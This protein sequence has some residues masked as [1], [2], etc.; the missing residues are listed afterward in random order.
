MHCGVRAMF[1]PEQILQQQ[2]VAFLK[3]A[4]PTLLFFH[5]PNGG[6]RSKVEASILKSM[7][8][9]AG[10]A[11]LCFIL[12]GARVGFIELKAT[13]GTASTSQ[14]TFRADCELQGVPYA[15]CRSLAE[16]EGTL[17]AWGLKSRARVAA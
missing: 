2:V 16:V 8:V 6:G 7:G 10:V 12:P 3:V 15:E 5:T 17:A 1:R 14:K 13:N 4:H 11:D 9:R